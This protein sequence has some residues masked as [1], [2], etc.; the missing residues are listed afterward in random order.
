MRFHLLTSTARSKVLH[1]YVVKQKVA[2]RARHIEYLIGYLLYISVHKPK[3][4]KRK[5]A[6]RSEDPRLV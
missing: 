3:E 2:E 5:A 6:E 4:N 1:R